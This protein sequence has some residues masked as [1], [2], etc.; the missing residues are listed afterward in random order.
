MAGRKAFAIEPSCRSTRQRTRKSAGL[1]EGGMTGI[2]LKDSF[3]ELSRVM[4][5]ACA[6]DGQIGAQASIDR[7][8]PKAGQ[9]RRAPVRRPARQ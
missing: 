6:G 2:G 4:V 5:L 8:G 9:R 1:L 3:M 7:S